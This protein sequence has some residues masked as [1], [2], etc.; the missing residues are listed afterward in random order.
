MCFCMHVIVHVHLCIKIEDIKC[1]DKEVTGCV[2]KMRSQDIR[3]M[4][5]G[6]RW[7]SPTSR[8]TGFTPS[9]FPNFNPKQK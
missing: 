1:I 4:W 9:S 7:K 5:F 8:Y 6:A 2:D 3:E